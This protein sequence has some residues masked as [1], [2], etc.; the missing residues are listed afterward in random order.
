MS[1]PALPTAQIVACSWE[2]LSNHQQLTLFAYFLHL[3]LVVRQEFSFY[4]D[5][6]S[7]HP[8]PA[9]LR[10]ITIHTG[11][12]LN[13]WWPVSIGPWSP[14]APENE[15]LKS[16]ICQTHKHSLPYIITR[17][18]CFQVGSP[19]AHLQNKSFN[20]WIWWI[21]QIRASCGVTQ[22]IGWTLRQP[23]LCRSLFIFHSI[24]AGIANAIASFSWMKILL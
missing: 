13:N 14:P 16:L 22:D 11:V 4:S 3:H 20:S 15:S 10:A 24:E 17:A 9:S 2:A 5:R 8:L 7:P 23:L 12:A 1:T 21:N 19:R 18:Q 6:A